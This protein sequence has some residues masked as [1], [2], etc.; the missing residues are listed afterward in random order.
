MQNH[1]SSRLSRLWEKFQN[2]LYREAFASAQ[3]SNTI[4]AQISAIREDR[5]WTQSDLAAA[6][7]MAQSRISLLEDPSYDRVNI[8]TLKRIASAFDVGLAVT[9]VPFSGVLKQA[10]DDRDKRFS[11]QSFAEDICPNVA[12]ENWYAKATVH[13]AVGSNMAIS[14]TVG[15]GSKAAVRIINS[16]GNARVYAG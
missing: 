15:A 5:G 8:T 11:V 10:I 6:T 3:I 16:E 13:H 12:S 1:T 4:A 2:K 9:F 14:A 7:G